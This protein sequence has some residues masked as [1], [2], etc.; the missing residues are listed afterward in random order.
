MKK[1]L[2]ILLGLS[3][4]SCTENIS[5]KAGHSDYKVVLIYSINN[6]SVYCKYLIKRY[7]NLTHYGVLISDVNVVD[8]IGKFKIGDMV[9]FNL[10]HK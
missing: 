7:E 10:V 9:K 2:I 8:S 6:D 1:L 4:I 5:I 3:M